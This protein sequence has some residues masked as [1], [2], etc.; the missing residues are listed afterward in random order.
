M[1]TSNRGFT[2]IEMMIA[3]AVLAIILTMAMP[4][5]REAIDNARLSTQVNEF[6]TA[7][8]TA[9]A[10]AIRTGGPIWLVAKGDDF[11]NGWCVRSGSEQDD[12]GSNSPS[13]LLD[14]PALNFRLELGYTA[15]LPETHRFQFNRLGAL[16]VPSNATTIEIAP[17][18]CESGRTKRLIDINAIGRISVTRKDC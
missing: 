6:V 17:K 5:F 11:N 14:H 15:G 3:I 16:A 8:N 18:G 2:L 4:S 9:R 1:Q 13:D 12:C 7:F 10:E